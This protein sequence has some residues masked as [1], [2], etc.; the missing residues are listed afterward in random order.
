MLVPYQKA[1]YTYFQNSDTLKS[2]FGLDKLTVS[3]IFIHLFNEM[4][5]SFPQY[6]Y[7][8]IY[9]KYTGYISV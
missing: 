8:E 7:L 9:A 5:P 4:A 3:K 6:T 1:V 2:K